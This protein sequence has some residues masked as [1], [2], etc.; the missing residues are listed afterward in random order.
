[1]SEETDTPLKVPGDYASDPARRKWLC[2]VF[3]VN[4]GR[5]IGE[6]VRYGGSSVTPMTIEILPPGD[7][8]PNLV[9]LE[10]ERDAANHGKLRQ[11]LIRDADVAS[12]ALLLAEVTEDA[13]R[14]TREWWVGLW[15]IG[16]DDERERAHARGQ[17]E[18]T[19]GGAVGVH[20]DPAI[21]AED[22]ARSIDGSEKVKR[23]V[24]KHIAHSE[25]PG[26]EPKDPGPTPVTTTLTLDDVH[27]AVDLLATCSSGT[28]R[29]SRRR[30]WPV[31]NQRFS[32]TG[33]PSFACHGFPAEPRLKDQPDR[34]ATP[35]A[36]R[37]PKTRLPSGFVL[38]YY[39]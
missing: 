2:T 29:S 18:V 15:G 24:D 16:E 17:W 35:T 10:E 27:G 14:L 38:M 32:T 20:L 39:I 19:Y 33:R 4:S 9:R 11:A 23:H 6:V 36:T 7:G 31:W 26:L 25:D 13:N 1:M 5:S 28:T 8:K 22:L 21:P 37:P 34:T 30:T 3:T 12:L